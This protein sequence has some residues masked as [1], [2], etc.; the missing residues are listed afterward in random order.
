MHLLAKR[1]VFYYRQLHIDF[2]F[3]KDFLL[4]YFKYNQKMNLILYLFD[5]IFDLDYFKLVFFYYYYL[6]IFFALFCSLLQLGSLIL[7]ARRA[8]LR[9]RPARPG[10]RHLGLL[11]PGR[12]PPRLR[13]RPALPLPAPRPTRTRRLRAAASRASR[14]RQASK[15]PSTSR[16]SR[17]P[18]STTSRG[19]RSG[20]GRKRRS[21]KR[22]QRPSS[23]RVLTVRPRRGS[24]VR[25]T[26]ARP[27]GS[28]LWCLSFSVSFFRN[29]RFWSSVQFQHRV[30]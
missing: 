27:N 1:F 19:R 8:P 16:S 13:R 30:Y 21:G 23:R 28:F 12:L 3:L 22:P 2:V 18:A 25:G 20:R 4:Q 29:R 11:P 26:G 14:P 5:F 7:Q 24:T 15:R 6:S 17:S 9:A 10:P